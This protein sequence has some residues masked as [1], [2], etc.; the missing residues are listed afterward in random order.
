MVRK[1]FGGEVP[2]TKPLS[3]AKP[4]PKSPVCWRLPGAIRAT[5]LP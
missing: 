3:L 1:R 2:V 5:S 4:H